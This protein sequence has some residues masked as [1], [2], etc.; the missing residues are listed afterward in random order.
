[1]IRQAFKTFFRSEIAIGISLI[2][3]T[4]VALLTAN[5]ARNDIYFDFFAI[6]APINLSF[7]GIYKDLTLLEWVNDALMAIFFLLVGLELK[8]E[9]LVG[10]LSSKQKVSL[11]AIAAIGGIVIP[12]LIFSYFNYNNLEN[13]RGFA[14]PCATDIAF[15]YG[16]ISLFGK[17]LSNSLKVFLVA[18]AVLDDLA[19]ILIIAFFY[20]ENISSHYLLF[21]VLIMMA[22]SLFNV[23]EVKKIQPY[24][25][26]GSLL[27]LTVLKSGLH[28]TLAGVLLAMFIPLEVKKK[29]IL[30]K[31]AHQIAPSVNFLI[32]PI[33]AFANAGVKLDNFTLDSFLHPLVLGVALGLFLGKQLGVM[34]FSFFAVKIKISNLPRGTDW[35]EFYAAAIFTGIGFTMSLFIGS[36]AFINHAE[37][38]D[39]TKIG[40]LIGSL[41]SVIFGVLII[42]LIKIRKFL[43]KRH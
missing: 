4:A 14:V 21:S 33:F 26:L 35:L 8:R 39:L 27:W 22:L 34:L 36:L 19:A 13:M 31:F 7:I 28:A 10:E 42:Y 15:A 3:A 5:S 37:L 40:V 6:H 32:L 1:M 2:I 11:P 12:L 41:A 20:S 18:L 43:K 9:I 24:L 25:I 17:T 29:P 16:M 38:L 23:L 30:T